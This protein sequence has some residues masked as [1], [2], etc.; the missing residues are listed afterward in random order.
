M[1][2]RVGLGVM[3]GD[4]VLLGEEVRLAVGIKLGWIVASIDVVRVAATLVVWL[5]LVQP[6]A[7]SNT[8]IAEIIPTK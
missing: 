1:A 7:I 4:G 5:D 3:L 2:V 6:T 8:T